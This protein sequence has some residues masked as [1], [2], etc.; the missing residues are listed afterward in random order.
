L[1]KQKVEKS[2]KLG[3]IVFFRWYLSHVCCKCPKK[4]VFRAVIFWVLLFQKGVQFAWA[5]GLVGWP[6]LMSSL[7]AASKPVKPIHV[8]AMVYDIAE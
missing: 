4:I 5:K 8:L 1:N 2:S 7:Q 6:F 3:K